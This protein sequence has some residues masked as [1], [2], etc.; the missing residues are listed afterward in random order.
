MKNSNQLQKTIQ[1]NV[2]L[3]RLQ[4]S[5]QAKNSFAYRLMN[6]FITGN[7]SWSI[8][9]NQLRTC[10]TSGNGRFTTNL[11]Y[12]SDVQLLCKKLRLLTETGND[13]PKG[14][15]TGNYVRI[16]TKIIN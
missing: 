4:E 12:T 9:G 3:K 15:K 8:I 1:R 11:D 13:A 7:D 5:N 14:G 16:I 2:L 6:D 10:H